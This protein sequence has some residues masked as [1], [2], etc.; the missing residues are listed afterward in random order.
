MLAAFSLL[1]ALAAPSAGSVPPGAGLTTLECD[2]IG[3][4]TVPRGGGSAA[5]PSDGSMWLVQELT[6]VGGGE[7]FHATFGMKTGLTGRGTATCTVTEVFDG[8][9]Y[10]VTATVVRVR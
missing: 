2:P 7:T 6:G 3:T 4:V 8:V 5:W 10:T 9:T 1:V